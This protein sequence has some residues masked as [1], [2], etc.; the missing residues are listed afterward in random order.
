[1]DFSK[2]QFRACLTL[3]KGHYFH[4]E[5]NNLSRFSGATVNSFLNSITSVLFKIGKLP[6][7]CYNANPDF[8]LK[9]YPL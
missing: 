5:I 2:F 6:K 1:M 9:T 7:L 8:E 4:P 3:S